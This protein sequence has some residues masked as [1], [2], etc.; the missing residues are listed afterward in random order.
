[1]SE[2]KEKSV[3]EAL[4]PAYED[5]PLYEALAKA[6][7][8]IAPV[9]KDARN[10]LY[11]SSYATLGAV[12]EACRKPLADNG[13]LLIQTPGYAPGPNGAG[14]MKLTTRIVHLASGREL[15]FEMA[16]PI[17]KQ[18]AQG[19]G[20]AI[21]YAR[22][23]ALTSVLGMVMEDDD[24][25]AASAPAPRA[26]EDQAYRE[27]YPP[28]ADHADAAARKPQPRGQ[29]LLGDFQAILAGDF[30]NDRNAFAEALSNWAGRQ[31]TGSRDLSFE[32]VQK[33]VQYWKHHNSRSAVEPRSGAG[34]WGRR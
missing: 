19:V 2:V 29:A 8:A 10:P 27:E 13:L 26:R 14:Q 23:Y 17:E 3:A 18:T 32:E 34:V 25:N 31:V 4:A 1:M 30:R 7:A 11:K 12:M 28:R 9:V 6:G 16:L 21:T 22:R 33:F 24:G 5:A 15:K 20:S